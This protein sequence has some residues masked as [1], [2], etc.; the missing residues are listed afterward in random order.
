MKL[1]DMTV[2]VIGNGVVG[3]AVARSYLEHVKEVRCWDKEKTRT[4]HTLLGTLGSDVTFLCLPTPSKEDG[5]CDLTAIEGF[6]QE[7]RGN[8][9]TNTTIESNLVLRSTVP[10]ETTKRLAEEYNLPNL[11]HSPEFLTARCATLDAQIPSRNII[12][13]PGTRDKE[14]YFGYP[15]AG[16]S[17]PLATL[18]NLYAA[19][20]PST[21]IHYMTSDESEAVKLFQ[22]SFFATKIAFWN[23]MREFADKKRLQWD[24]VLN[25][26]LAD[27]RIHPSHT[28]VPGPDG[29]R[30][31]GGA[32]LPKDLSSMIAQFFDSHVS[33]ELLVAVSRR[34]D[35]D[36]SRS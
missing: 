28:Q 33:P 9:V 24:T 18:A 19:R 1:S 7:V 12:G 16:G 22:N 29:K 21:P 2:G 13:Y 11:V 6:F 31:F 26:I 14:G 30:G 35:H 36:R 15:M 32:C 34:N 27:G 3:Q 4:T 17:V 5:S 23:E 10:V 25:A 20:F 8:Y